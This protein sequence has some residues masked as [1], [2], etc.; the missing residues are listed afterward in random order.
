MQHATSEIVAATLSPDFGRMLHSRVEALLDERD[1][2]FA[3]W[4]KI[5]TLRAS[6]AHGAMA[7]RYEDAVDVAR[8]ANLALD[9]RARVFFLVAIRVLAVKLHI[10]NEVLERL[11]TFL[12]R[13]SPSTVFGV[14]LEDLSVKIRRKIH[15]T[16]T[17]KNSFYSEC[18][19]ICNQF[20]EK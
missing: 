5:Q 4:T 16:P 12:E 1:G 19:M 18:N 17:T 9:A 10:T 11:A 15:P 7:A 14:L 20:F 8:A 6:R 13:S 3:K 2:P